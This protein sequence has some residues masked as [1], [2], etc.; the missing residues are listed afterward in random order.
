MRTS[1]QF[2][3]LAKHTFLK[4]DHFPGCQKMSLK[5]R[6]EGAPNFRQIFGATSPSSQKV[7]FHAKLDPRA[8]FPS[9]GATRGTRL[10]V[11]PSQRW[12]GLTISLFFGNI[13]F[14]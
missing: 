11:W 1:G 8:Q 9:L 4:S 14:T 6:I 3:V 13:I 7:N 10:W 12:F 5:D 2:L